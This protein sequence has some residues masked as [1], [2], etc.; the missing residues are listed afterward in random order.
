MFIFR[1]TFCPTFNPYKIFTKSSE[2]NDFSYSCKIKLSRSCRMVK[3]FG[4]FP[5]ELL[6]ETRKFASDFYRFKSITVSYL[7]LVFELHKSSVKQVETARD[8]IRPVECRC[9][10]VSP[11]IS[12]FS[13]FLHNSAFIYNQL[14]SLKPNKFAFKRSHTTCVFFK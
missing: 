9:G 4:I 3:I 14:L 10:E 7:R 1:V 6:A 8:D 11:K 12:Q 5:Q 2:L 13:D